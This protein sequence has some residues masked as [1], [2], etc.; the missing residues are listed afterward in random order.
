VQQL[1]AIARIKISAIEV[2]VKNQKVVQATS[3]G[4]PFRPHPSWL[5]APENRNC[6]ISFPEDAAP[7]LLDGIEIPP[8]GKHQYLL[9]G[10]VPFIPRE[11]GQS[12]QQVGAGVNKKLVF[13]C[14]NSLHDLGR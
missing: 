7:Q 3:Q 4:K 12:A 2:F 14:V 8:G 6:L 10:R 1:Q 13:K 5:F 9:K 11:V